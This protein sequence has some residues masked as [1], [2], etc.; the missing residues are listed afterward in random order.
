MWDCPRPFVTGRGNGGSSPTPLPCPGAVLET[1]RTPGL[2]HPFVVQINSRASRSL[3]ERF[4]RRSSA[5]KSVVGP[6]QQRGKDARR[7]ARSDGRRRRATRRISEP[8]HFGPR[9]CRPKDFGPLNLQASA[10]RHDRFA[11][12]LL[13]AQERCAGAYVT[14]KRVAFQ[15]ARTRAGPGGIVG[16]EGNG[17]ARC[18]RSAGNRGARTKLIVRAAPSGRT[19]R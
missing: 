17:K 7:A 1:V 18:R 12:G 10:S 6:P 2:R 19:S 3:T 16:P 8:I 5:S 9:N 14:V 15:A 11:E 4:R 13:R